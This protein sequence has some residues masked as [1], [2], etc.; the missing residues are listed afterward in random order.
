MNH[1]L[2]IE[3]DLDILESLKLLL[4]SE[5]YQVS[6]AS[7]GVEGLPLLSNKIDLVILDIMMPGM[8]G[9]QIC[10]E[11]RKSSI[12]PVLFLT[13]KSSIEDKKEGFSIGA[14]D[15]L[16]KP[17]SSVELLARINALLRRYQQYTLASTVNH[18]PEC[19][20]TRHN[21]RLNIFNNNVC[22]NN[23][24]LKLTDTEYALLRLFFQNPRHIFS[25]QELYEKIWNEP[26]FP[27]SSNTVMVH[28]RRLRSKI[29]INSKNP[30]IITTVWGKGYRLG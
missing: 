27:D 5:N 15:Y 26:F 8:S 14:D 24:E 1:I 12:V 6:T 19:W 9:L 21:I 13:A 17:F 20:I 23:I 11:I 16:V 22:M 28:I 25:I 29:E 3:D 4:E 18:L 7:N 10:E 2:I 30:I